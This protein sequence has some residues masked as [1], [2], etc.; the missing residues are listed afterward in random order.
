LPELRYKQ[1]GYA[2][3]NVTDLDRSLAF[4]RE[5]LGLELNPHVERAFG[6]LLL[7]SPA[8]SCNVALYAASEPG[9]R[10]VAFELEAAD[11]LDVARRHL[12]GLG[13]RTWDVPD[14]DLQ[15]FAQSAAFRFAEPATGLT[16][17][18]YAG[19]GSHPPQPPTQ[20]LTNISR[21]GHVVVYVKDA[22]RFVNFFLE[23]LN[24]RASD[25]V[26]DA[27]FLRCF[28]VPY[29]HS[30]AVVPGPENRLNHI[31]FLVEHLDD[32]GRALYRLKAQNVPIVFGPGRHPPSGSVFL[33]FTD[34][35]GFTFEFST[36]MEEFAEVDPR[37][38]RH[39]PLTPASLDYWGSPRTKD[40]G[41]VGR[42]V[43]E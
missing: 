26:G 35:D 32:V 17:E 16:V 41:Q 25:F 37:D 31:N 38:P 8:S 19:D 27:A 10:R 28:P 12:D 4:H 7:R 39:L 3:L 23:E 15:A 40:Y 21:L 20:S 30:F 5:T 29:H 34:P 33:Y 42:F 43:L 1:L 2:A 14:A 9:L 24:F 18:L 11:Y 13:V 6:A 22:P 36:G